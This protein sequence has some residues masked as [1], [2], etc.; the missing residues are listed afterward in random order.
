MRSALLCLALAQI[1]AG[2]GLARTAAAQSQGIEEVVVTGTYIRRQSQ[3]DAPSPLVN[4]THDDLAATGYN[5]IGR[6]IERLTINTGSQNNADAFTQN[7]TTGTSNI[8]LRGL[9][10]ASTLVLVNGRRQTQS[11]AATDTGENFVDTSSLPPLIAFENIEILKD[12]A[13]ALYGSEAVAGVVNF[14]TRRNFHGFDLQLGAQDSAKYSQDD[15]EISGLYGAGNDT[16]H[17]LVAFNHLRRDPLTTAERRLSVPADD[18]SQ[19]GMPGSFLIP[20][21]PGNPVYAAVW[22]AAYDSNHNNIAD[23]VEPSLGLPAVPGAQPPVFADQNC[24]TIAAQDPKVVPAIARSVPTPLGN[25]PLG[26]CQFDFGTFYSLV[27]KERRDSAYFEL[28]HKLRDGLDGRFEI[29]VADNEARRDNSPSFPFAAFPTVLA[30]HPDNPYGTDVRFIGRIIGAG[31]TP[32]ESVHDSKTTRFAGS[33]TGN[34][35]D[36]W[37]WELGAQFSE[38]DFSVAVPDV[39]VDHF[40]LAIQGLGGAGCNPATGTPGVGPCAYFNP[41]GTSLTGTGTP[42]TPAMFD[43]LLG[44]ERFDAVSQLTSVEG[45][46]SRQLGELVGGPVGIAVGAQYRREALSYDYDD[47]ANRDNYLFLTGNP[48]FGNSRNV[49]AAFVELNLPFSDS[50]N[51]QAAARYEHYGHGVSS[52]DPKLSLLWRPSLKFSLRASAGTSFRAPSLFQAFGTRT[53]LNELIDPGVGTA[54][55][56][57]VRNKPNP[58][59]APL[60]P[61]QA[62][63]LNV[64]VSFAPSER[65]D[66]SLDYWSFD[67]RD[68]I[69]AQNPQAILNA[70]VL[71]DAQARSQV[72]RDAGSGLLLRVDAYYGNASSLSTDGF[73][74]RAAHNFTLRSGGS[75]RVGADATYIA[76][77]ELED[78]QAGRIDGAGKRNF[79]NF[80]TST[81]QWRANAFVNWQHDRHAVNA[82]VHYIDSYT[83]DEVKLGQGPSFYRK[84]GSNVTVDAQYALRLRSEKAPTLAF[85]AINLLDEAPPHV[86]TNGGFDSKVHDPRG[87]MYYARVD[88][89]F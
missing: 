22:S 26:L 74:L 3:L 55:F 86:Q 32:I 81:P 41:F 9:G 80:G 36:V 44:F 64:G 33:L 49:G 21:R 73:D 4:L 17:V 34:V 50:V 37:I 57:P 71:G 1:V 20:T 14:I 69:I 46:A 82:F 12:G 42:N 28:T 38:N 10:V 75:L 70:A 7:T 40:N 5:D 53:T 48:D 56:F 19:A 52:T 43:Y 15:N 8:N 47:N 27:P 83:D 78:P 66:L 58:N 6:V 18:L 39:L 84:I 29:H 51:L 24:T 54:Q 62:N 67:Y 31:G 88:F 35:N 72:V 68:V 59:G 11:A 16:T 45:F 85:G 87:R 60:T 30:S 65:W 25:V 61:E 77:Y 76:S 89:H 63:V 2:A 23:F 79:A 13:T